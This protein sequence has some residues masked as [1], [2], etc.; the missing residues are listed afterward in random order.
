MKLIFC[1]KCNDI[2]KLNYNDQTCS[3]KTSGGYY[4]TNGL[5]AEYWGNAI[6]IGINWSSFLNTIKYQP[7]QGQGKT[8]EAFV[9]PF[10]CKTMKKITKTILEQ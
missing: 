2:I 8:F 9:I 7:Q 6:P 1:P 4:L 3:C 5:N 10:K